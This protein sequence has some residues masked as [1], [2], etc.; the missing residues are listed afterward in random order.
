MRDQC[1]LAD[2]YSYLIDLGSEA[3]AWEFLRRNSDYQAAN[4]SIASLD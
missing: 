1:R 4:Q 2:V 3:F